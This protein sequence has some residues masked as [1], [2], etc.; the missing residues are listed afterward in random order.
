MV[1]A[2]IDQN[3]R[4]DLARILAHLAACT[5]HERAEKTLP[6]L[7]LCALSQEIPRLAGCCVCHVV[8]ALRRKEMMVLLDKQPES[9]QSVFLEDG[10]AHQRYFGWK[11]ALDL[12]GALQVLLRVSAA[13]CSVVILC[14]SQKE[15]RRL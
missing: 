1:K 4:L 3:T 14:C 15:G 5:L 7:Y 8:S 10:W 12:P 9:Y 13:R 2:L 11:V 6:V